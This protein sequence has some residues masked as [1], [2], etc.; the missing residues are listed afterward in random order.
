MHARATPFKQCFLTFS[1]GMVL[2]ATADDFQG[3]THMVPFDEGESRYSLA[4][5]NSAV[6]Q[7]QAKIDR[8]EIRLSFDDQSGYL[9][10]VMKE[11]KVSAASQMLVFSKTS[12]QRERISPN[13]PR[14]IYFND[15]VY[16]GFIPGSPKLEISVAD[17]ALGGVF[18]TLEQTKADRPKFVR[19]DQCLEC[20]A[21]AKSMG[22]PGHLVRSSI[23]DE[24]GTVDLKESLSQVTQRTPFEERWGGWY[25]TGL[26]GGLRHRGNLVNPAAFARNFKAPNH[27][28]NLTNLNRFFA[29]EDYPKPT[30]D[31]VALMVLEHQTHLHNMITRL[32]YESTL[33][34][35][36]YGHVNYLRNQVEA[37]L[38]YCLFTEEAPLTSRIS[39]SPEYRR[40][41]EGLGPM[42]ARG[43]SLR[44][45]DLQTRLFTF[46]CSFLIYSDAFDALPAP[47][48]D[49]IYKRLWDILDGT[50]TSDDFKMITPETR[51]AVREI[52]VA[53][54]KGLPDYWKP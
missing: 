3:A 5:E 54:K 50:D 47:I 1:L 17:P 25:V 28:G 30:S 15:D 11:L 6:S 23:S 41:F 2:C 39:G 46:P 45:F 35:K 37:F 31:I 9:P 24:L 53:T 8:G 27:L 22:V 14:A 16:L 4:R 36:Q 33:M 49:K 13:T 26:H 7:L 52:L 38:R 32:H 48:R 51:R 21:S 42:D 19:T 40:H 44:Q 18:Y 43:R 12:L 20:H 29:V 10:A 34:L